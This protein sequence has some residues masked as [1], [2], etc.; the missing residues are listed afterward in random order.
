MDKLLKE[1][2][3]NHA[4]GY[5]GFAKFFNKVKE[6]KPDAEKKVVNKWYREQEIT[7]LDKK[8]SYKTKNLLRIVAP[9]LSFQMDHL[10]INRALKGTSN[11]NNKIIFLLFVDIVSRKAYAYHQTNRN[12]TNVIASYEM[13]LNDLRNDINKLDG[14]YNEYSRDKPV[15]IY[16]DNEF[17]KKTFIDYNQQKGIEINTQTA[18]DDHITKGNRLGIIDRLTR[19]IKQMLMRLAYTSNQFSIPKVIIQLVEN[20]NNTQHNTLHNHTPNEVF[21]DKNLRHTLHM[22]ALEHNE[23][24]T[25]ELKQY[26]SG[27]KVRIYE[28]NSEFDKEHPRFSKDIYNVDSQI[29]NKYKINNNDGNA[30]KRLFKHHELQA[31]NNVQKVNTIDKSQT[32]KK[33]K[34]IIQTK[35][36]LKKEMINKNNI[37]SG[38]R[39]RQQTNFY[40]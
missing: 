40:K 16:S 11:E 24:R 29:G 2:Y 6:L 4:T 38:K 33:A 27:D 30:L 32:I 31:V 19:T 13:F 35:K 15:I 10:F 1:L 26:N 9:P 21:N 5:T 14:T 7:Q 36:K 25:Q 34:K 28:Q 18:Q 17:N 23:E 20:Y 8:P 3:Y 12:L 39:D 22:E 37:V